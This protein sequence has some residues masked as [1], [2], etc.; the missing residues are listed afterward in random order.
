M[1]ETQ[2]TLVEYFPERQQT[3]SSA[4]AIYVLL[5]PIFVV[6]IVSSFSRNLA[7]PS[8]IAT[9]AFMLYRRRRAKSVPL[10]V[11]EVRDGQLIIFDGRRTELLRA[12]L[13]DVSDIRLDTKAIQKVQ[14]NLSSGVPDVRFI[15]SRVGPSIDN[16]RIEV[17]LGEPSTS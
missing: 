8:G 4:T 17:C 6:I 3:S 5:F 14:E 13:A 11:L 15:D 12:S 16:A 1:T 2:D 9:A 7:W 10:R